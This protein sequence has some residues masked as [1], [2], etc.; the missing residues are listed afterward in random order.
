[1]G[2]APDFTCEDVRL[3]HYGG[4]DGFCFVLFFVFHVYLL[5]TLTMKMYLRG[6]VSFSVQF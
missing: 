1:M 6:I 5:L 4:T 2:Q 3:L